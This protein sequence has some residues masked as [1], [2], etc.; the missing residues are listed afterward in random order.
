MH[1]GKVLK[2]DDVIRPPLQGGM[3]REES[4]GRSQ[5]GGAG[6]PDLAGQHDPCQR[7]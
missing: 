4:Y 2:R 7:T 3:K 1:R 6:K 5:P